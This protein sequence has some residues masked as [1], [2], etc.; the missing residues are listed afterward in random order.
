MLTINK[1]LITFEI[2]NISKLGKEW[3]SHI[4]KWPN[5]ANEYV[6]SRRTGDDGDINDENEY[7]WKLSVSNHIQLSTNC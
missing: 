3:E 1:H 4:R 6:E 5:F 2:E 7:F